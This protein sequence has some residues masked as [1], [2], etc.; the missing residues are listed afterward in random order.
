MRRPPF[1]IVFIRMDGWHQISTANGWV[2][3]NLHSHG[4][5]FGCIA[6]APQRSPFAAVFSKSRAKPRETCSEAVRPRLTYRPLAGDQPSLG[7]WLRQRSYKSRHFRRS[8]RRSC[9]PCDSGWVYTVATLPLNSG[10]LPDLPSTASM[11]S[12]I[13]PSLS[14]EPFFGLAKRGTDE[15]RV[16]RIEILAKLLDQM[17]KVLLVSAGEGGTAAIPIAL[18]P[19]EAGDLVFLR[20]G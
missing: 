11:A 5:A 1:S 20:A 17:N 12:R 16:R 18:P 6:L 10:Y 2:A 8:G 3:P 7:P 14:V 19:E 13:F 15:L 9:R 4:H